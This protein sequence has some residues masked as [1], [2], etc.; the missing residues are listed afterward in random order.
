[1]S[2]APFSAR[3]ATQSTALGLAAA[4]LIGALF[5]PLYLRNLGAADIVGDDEAREVGI[6]QDMTLRGH[7]MLPRFNGTT[8][9]DKPVLYH[10]L[11][12]ATC[13]RSLSC[14]ERAVRLPS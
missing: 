11:G 10:W 12:A 2:E 3:A 5:A 14:D 7:W 6:I 13:S 4:L 1:M 8:F 9:P